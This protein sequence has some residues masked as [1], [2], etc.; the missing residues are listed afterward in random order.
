[1]MKF[2]FPFFLLTI[3][4]Y[5]FA[6]ETR[7][8]LILTLEDKNGTTDQHS[9]SLAALYV[10]SDE[11]ASPFLEHGPFTAT[12]SGYLSLEKRSRLYFSFSGNGDAQL[13]IDD[14]LLHQETA[15]LG[16]TESANHR[17]SSG[18]RKFELTY[19]SPKSGPAQFRLYWR[20]RDFARETVPAKVFRSTFKHLEGD[21]LRAGRTLFADSGC[22]HCHKEEAIKPTSAMPELLH[23]APN[24]HGI[25]SRLNK[26][27]MVSW[28]E[29][30]KAHR[31]TARMPQMLH[32]EEATVARDIAQWLSDQKGKLQAPLQASSSSSVENGKKLFHQLGCL[33]CHDTDENSGVSQK[34]H[35]LLSLD[36]VGNKFQ[37]G[38]IRDFLINPGKHYPWIRMPDFSLSTLEATQLEHYLRTISKSNHLQSPAGNSI[39]GLDAAKQKGCFNC[40]SDEIQLHLDAP[41]LSSLNPSEGCLSEQKGQHPQYDFSPEEKILISKFIKTAKNS[42]QK[43]SLREFAT[44]QTSSLQCASCHSS[45]GQQSYLS[46]LSDHSLSSGV[47]RTEAE[48]AGK[49][50]GPPDLNL[51]GEKLRSDWMTKLFK[52]ELSYK[53]RPWIKMKMPAFPSRAELLAKG[54]AYSQGFPAIILKPEFNDQRSQVGQKLVS[55]DGGFACIACHAVGTKP[56][57][58]PFEG[59]GL[60]FSYSRERLNHEY[61]LRWMLNPQR[62]SPQSIMPRYS[63][64]EGLSTLSDIL[65]G[66]A[67]D[68]F[69]AI[70]SYLETLE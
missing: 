68:Q 27:W 62:I 66:N 5:S 25:G 30:P 46:A 10:E 45:A 14:D 35:F 28:I 43:K 65:E 40:H 61:Y 1:M 15:Q 67:T 31:A 34:Q 23:K 12:W 38:A 8:G 50:K 9:T 55:T 59:Q 7:T 42:L 64:D 20:G 51:I 21:K 39:H 41:Q 36:S 11:S 18:L 4:T 2:T 48:S 29:N 13:K 52:D 17:L 37:K 49:K 58:A 54:L 57:L 63:D 22:I 3:L 6:E 53:P 32:G 19:K 70:W 60:N 33:G 69:N 44:R 24:F 26:E 47:A 16:K 56:A